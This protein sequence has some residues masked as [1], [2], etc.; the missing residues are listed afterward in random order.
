M[1]AWS[2][3]VKRY[4]KKHKMSYQQANTNSKCKEAYQKKK[5]GS[6]RK[7]SP[8]RKTS[9][10][11]RLNPPTVRNLENQEIEIPNAAS[12]YTVGNFEAT[13]DQNDLIEYARNFNGLRSRMLTPRQMDDLNGEIVRTIRDGNGH[14]WNARIEYQN[15]NYYYI[16]GSG[17]RM[18]VGDGR[19]PGR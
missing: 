17:E 3:H 10:R 16:G 2:E 19:I 6:R 13:Q 5:L 14:N 7:T 9:Q 4:A 11:R 18:L 8:R 1:S 15:P 12:V